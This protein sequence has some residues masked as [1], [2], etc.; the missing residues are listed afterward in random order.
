[1]LAEL[2]EG[3]VLMGWMG[4]RHANAQEAKEERMYI[5][6]FIFNFD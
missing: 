2:S 4:P 6:F 3:R 5:Y 1:V